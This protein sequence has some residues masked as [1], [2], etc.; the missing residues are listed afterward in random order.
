MSLTVVACETTT[1]TT[2]AGMLRDRDGNVCATFVW[3]LMRHAPALISPKPDSAVLY[4]HP[5]PVAQLV[6]NV[7]L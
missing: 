7:S 3:V 4:A 6:G 2:K 1:T 5:I